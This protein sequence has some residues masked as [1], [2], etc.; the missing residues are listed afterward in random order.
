MGRRARA[1]VIAFIRARI[2]EG[3]PDA[4]LPAELDRLNGGRRSVERFAPY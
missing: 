2:P 3:H 4:Y 1:V